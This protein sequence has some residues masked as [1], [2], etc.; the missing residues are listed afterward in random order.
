MRDVL[1]YRARRSV[2]Q[3]EKNDRAKVTKPSEPLNLAKWHLNSVKLSNL[4]ETG[5][6]KRHW[7]ETRVITLYLKVPDLINALTV[8]ISE[9]RKRIDCISILNSELDCQNSDSS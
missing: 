2:T 9:C 4:Q 7:R 1:D 6:L 5:L 8:F 3:A